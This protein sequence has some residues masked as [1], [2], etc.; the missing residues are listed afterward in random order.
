MKITDRFMLAGILMT[1]AVSALPSAVAQAQAQ[2]Q[3][4]NQSL[5]QEGKLTLEDIYKNHIYSPK[6]VMAFRWEDNG[7][8]F[9]TL[10]Q[11]PDTGGKDI[12]LNDIKTGEKTVAVA[13]SDLIPAGWTNPIQIDN[14]SWSPDRTKL[15]VYTNSKKVWRTNKRGD[16]WLYVP[17]TGELRQLGRKDF[18]PSYM[19]FAKFSPDGQKVAYVYKNNLYVENLADGQIS[20]LT[21]DGSDIIING[22]FDWVYE[23]ELHMQDGFRWS[24][25]SKSLA[26]WQFDTE[27]TGT[28]YMIDNID[29][30]YSTIIPLPYPKAGTTNSAARIGVVD[31][32]AATPTTRW[33]EFAGDPRE[34]Y[35]ARMEF[36]PGTDR[37]MIQRLNR[38][39]NTNWVYYGD[40]H[41]MEL[42]EVL[43]EK[44]EAFLDVH[45]DIVWLDNGKYFTWTSERDGWRHL[46]RVSAD[47]SEATLITKGDF[48]VV[49]V[50]RI[51]PKGGYVYYIASPDSPVDRY[52][53]RSRLDGKGEAERLTPADAPAG[54]HGY[55]ISPDA[56]YAMHT[57]SNSETPN[58]YDIVTLPK[59]KSVRVLEDNHELAARFDSI[60]HNPKEF[61]RVDIG[62]VVLDGWMIKP[63]GFDSTKRYPV[64]FYIYGEPWGTTV[65]NEWSGGDLWSRYLAQEGF[66]MMSID[67][68]GVN[69]P[70]GHQWRKC[71]YGKIGIIPPADHAAAVSKL[72]Q[73]YS[74]MDPDRIGIW[75]WSGGGSSTAHLMFKYPEIYSTGIAVA[76][77]YSLY[78]YD[79][80]YQERYQGLPSSNPQGYHDGSAINFAGGLEGNLLLIHGTGDDNV[81]Y[82]CCEMLVNELIRQNKMFDMLS[83]PMRT[84]SINER[85]NTSFHLYQSMFKYWKEN[86]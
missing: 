19:Q 78:L 77:V 20:Q 69:T 62:D 57:F 56:K 60:P 81:H 61:F 85:E 2:P 32:D 30:I 29:S 28:F 4:Q 42:T 79:T 22:Q 70:R 40:I 13:S 46:Y 12:V 48:D 80:I 52:L 73:T 35:L 14:F 65:Q 45:D 53:Y 72:F 9:L 1:A 39:Q 67:P 26:Y 84:H 41:T 66:I 51:D 5:T 11:N 75:G 10:E 24:P 47:G 86:L 7:H 64:I 71:V 16:Y 50:T 8:S 68:R 31:V 74:F 21:F 23:E 44:D 54:H 55:T 25:D 59:H 58:I 38:L 63:V 18:E 33:F 83:Y 36:V 6:G 76:G 15:M 3:V 49:S 27:G 17:E 34:H 82:Q 37:L 43:V